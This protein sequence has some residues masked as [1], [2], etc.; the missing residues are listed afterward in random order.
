MPPCGAVQR[1]SL[2]R[3]GWGS[4]LAQRIAFAAGITFDLQIPNSVELEFG[5]A[6]Q[7]KQ[8]VAAKVLPACMGLPICGV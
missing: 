8:N 1:P 2:N 6:G 7:T 3:L 4:R 5:L